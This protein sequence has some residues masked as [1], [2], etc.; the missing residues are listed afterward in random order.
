MY[1][2]FW[3]LSPTQLWAFSFYSFLQQA[4]VGHIGQNV[5]LTEWQT[6][7]IAVFWTGQIIS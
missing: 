1:V 5:S 6:N 3:D 4:D 7:K 2:K